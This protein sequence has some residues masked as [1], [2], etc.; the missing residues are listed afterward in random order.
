MIEPPQSDDARPGGLLDAFIALS[1]G[2]VRRRADIAA[3]LDQAVPILT[4]TLTLHWATGQGNRVRQILWSLYT[5]SHL[6]NLGDACSGLD[7]RIADALLI[8]IAARL[9]VGPEVE[10]TLGRILRASGEFARFDELE[11]STPPNLPVLYPP[12]AADS[13]TLRELADAMDLFSSNHEEDGQA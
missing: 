12:P 11:R 2:E 4:E 1:R 9:I 5:C 10:P 13:R 3:N 8:V 6:V 7:A